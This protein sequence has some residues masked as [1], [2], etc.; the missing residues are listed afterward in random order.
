M[1]GKVLFGLNRFAFEVQHKRG[2]LREIKSLL[3]GFS[4]KQLKCTGG[5]SDSTAEKK[6]L[7]MKNDD[8]KEL[9]RERGLKVSG[10]KADLV[11]RLLPHCTVCWEDVQLHASL[12]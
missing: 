3:S 12:E 9:C 7:S 4:Q 5:S 8:L 2:R 6:L 11:D 10:N 1:Q